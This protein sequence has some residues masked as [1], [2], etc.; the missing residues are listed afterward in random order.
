MSREDKDR[1]ICTVAE[2]NRITA[3]EAKNKRRLG[4]EKSMKDPHFRLLN[5]NEIHCLQRL[6][7]SDDFES[8]ENIRVRYHT[9]GGDFT[10]CVVSFSAAPGIWIM[11]GASHR[12]YKDKPNYIRGKILAF[13]RAVK[14]RPILVYSNPDLGDVPF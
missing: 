2:Y 13:R 6:G 10:V 9:T 7:I 12:S 5:A 4:G 14:T 3:L 11:S 8:K 1:V